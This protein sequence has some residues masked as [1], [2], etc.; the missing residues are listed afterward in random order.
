MD[1]FQSPGALGILYAEDFGLEP[2]R[3]PVSEP[4]IGSRTVPGLEQADV[5]AACAK[6]VR[7]AE[8]AWAETTEARRAHAL[9]TLVSQFGEARQASERQ[10][11]AVA[12]GIAQAALGIVAAMLPSLCGT[13]GDGETRALL[14]RLLPVLAR[15]KQVVVRVHAGLLA[16]LRCELEALEDGTADRVELRP[17][18]LP[19]GDVRL[20][21][22]D[23]GLSRDGAAIR[24]AIESGLTELGLFKP[25]VAAREARSLAHVQ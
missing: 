18:N 22:E 14:G 2:D 3:A 20:S 1:G 13:F 4:P 15:S 7:L 9:E 8:A 11:E 25:A 24:A 17:A 5:D 10:A 19:P 23:G 16:T 12:D 21:W 6:A